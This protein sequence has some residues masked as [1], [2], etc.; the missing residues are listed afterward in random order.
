MPEP[1]FLGRIPHL[2]VL[3]YL[4]FFAILLRLWL[5]RAEYNTLALSLR[6]VVIGL[7][8]GLVVATTYV[9]L[10]PYLRRSRLI[11]GILIV[12]DVAMISVI[13]ALTNNPE[14][15][16]FL[17]YYLPIF[18]AAGHLRGRQIAAAF[19]AVTLGL[20]AALVFQHPSEQHTLAV[21]GLIW[22]VFIP[23]EL[24]FLAVVLPSA[25]V[26]QRLSKRE[27]EVRTLLNFKITVD[28]LFD[29]KEILDLTAKTAVSILG[30][31]WGHLALLDR[32]TGMLAERSC[33]P[34]GRQ[35]LHNWIDYLGYLVSN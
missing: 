12:T 19:A 16:F 3:R 28:Q 23:R 25:F 14:T 35:L 10:K 4:I 8:G 22:R 2:L 5:H 13:Y 20:C 11:Q 21:S 6:L 30:A 1:D 29:E 32:S 34:K 9:T 18:T 15:D 7:M 17:F 24:F 31:D 33:I 26:F 27:S